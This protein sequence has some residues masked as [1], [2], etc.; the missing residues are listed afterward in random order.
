MG[1]N[2]WDCFGTTLTEAQA[3]V[4]A[5]AMA[6]QLKP[7]GWTFFTVD[8]QWYEGASRGHDY[9]AGALNGVQVKGIGTHSI[10]FIEYDLPDGY[11]KFRAR[12]ALSPGSQGKGS[13]EFLVL[14]DSAKIEVPKQRRISVS[15]AELGF[16]GACQALDL[17]NG[18]SLGALTNDFGR[19]IAIHGAG[20]YRLRSLGN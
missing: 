9:K 19:D 14:T 12:G 3:K 7:Y 18:I 2:S 13:V 17:W 4:Q 6:R 11:S 5:D 1:W 8:I 10:S 16:T 15:L 20:L